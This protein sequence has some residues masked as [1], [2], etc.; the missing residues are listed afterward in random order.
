MIKTNEI[1][2]QYYFNLFSSSAEI[3][4]SGINNY[5]YKWNVRDLQLNNAEI[6]LVQIAN[7]KATIT[8]ERQYPPKLFNTF[9][10]E[11]TVIYLDQNPV[12]FQTITLNTDNITYGSGTYDI[13]SSSSF[14]T[15]NTSKNNYLIIF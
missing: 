13:Y 4:K 2:R 8:E 12:Y 6:A 7:N 10:T 15:N 11:T 14:G 1:L 3:T 5:M 9:T